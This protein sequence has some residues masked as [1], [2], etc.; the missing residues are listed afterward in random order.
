MLQK[1][2]RKPS[3]RKKLNAPRARLGALSPIDIERV[4]AEHFNTVLGGSELFNRKQGSEAH[5]D[6]A[7]AMIEQLQAV[8]REDLERAQMELSPEER[9]Q[10]SGKLTL[11]RFCVKAIER[12]CSGEVATLD[13]AFGIKSTKKGSPARSSNEQAKLSVAILRHLLSGKSLESSVK[14]VSAKFALSVP[15]LHQI[16]KK[17][18]GTAFRH[19]KY[20]RFGASK[21]GWTKQ[22]TQILERLFESDNLLARGVK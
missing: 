13:Q 22:E 16:W 17:N 12:W 7:R 1:A 6:D 14:N 19:V 8:L 18:K 21:D 15:A 4:Y 2:R 11:K 20:E 10:Q 3:Q 9:W 5:P